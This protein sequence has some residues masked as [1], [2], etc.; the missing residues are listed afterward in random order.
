M[1][2]R[3]LVETGKALSYETQWFRGKYSGIKSKRKA[4]LLKS[5]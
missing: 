1:V 3:Q 4:D 2:W 5:L